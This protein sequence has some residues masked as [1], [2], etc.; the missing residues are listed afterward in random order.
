V[1][2]RTVKFTDTESRMV[3]AR[4]MRE[5]EM[6]CRYLIGRISG[7]QEDTSQKIVHQVN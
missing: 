3:V 1:V 4:S 5:V 6:K 7:L 2:P